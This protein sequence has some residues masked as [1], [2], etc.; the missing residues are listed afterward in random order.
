MKR[1]YSSSCLLMV[2][3][4][5]CA[6]ANSSYTGADGPLSDGGTSLTVSQACTKLAA[7]VCDRLSQC[8]PYQ[9]Q[10]YYGDQP[11]C[12]TRVQLTCAP[13]VQLNGSSWTP[14]RLTAC[15]A[16]YRNG[17]CADYF[18]TGG[19]PACRPQPGT[20]ADGAACANS[21]QCQS[22]FCSIGVSSCGTCVTPALAGAVCDSSKPCA[23]GLSCVNS[24]CA[25]AA[26]SGQ[27]CGSGKPACQTGLYCQSSVCAPQLAA[28]TP[29]DPA[30]LVA[31][32]NPLL[33][34]SC[35]S[36]TRTCQ[37]S[38]VVGAG[39]A[40]GT[41]GTTTVLCSGGGTCS[42]TGTSRKCAVAAK[43]GQSCGVAAGNA[44][45]ESPATCVS[46][47]CSIFDPATCK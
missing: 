14:D 35:N 8:S 27:A 9:L 3:L 10:L 28:G 13:Y 6:S 34:L 26:D 4:C 24:K 39:Q 36:T 44:S 46:G 31:Q 29:C 17:T 19:P 5:S 43:D 40:C 22:A 23:L 30:S 18:A 33:G 41:T 25:A 37:A 21:N 38:Q 7:A 20:L 15:A 16:G 32:C 11:G 45:C 1:F 47:V 12:V 2:W 42:G